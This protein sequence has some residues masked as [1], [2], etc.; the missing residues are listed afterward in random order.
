MRLAGASATVSVDLVMIYQTFRTY[1]PFSLY[2]GGFE[3]PIPL[4]EGDGL[5]DDALF[6]GSD[7]R[8]A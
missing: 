6:P 7:G 2:P 1:S 4:Q 8:S 3:I 5:A